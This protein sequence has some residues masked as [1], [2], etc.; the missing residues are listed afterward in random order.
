MISSISLAELRTQKM[1]MAQKQSALPKTLNA[2]GN[3]TSF[4]N[5]ACDALKAQV[6]FR[7]FKPISGI[8]LDKDRQNGTFR[9]GH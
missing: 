3:F 5:A 1:S 2:T 9:S 8:T 7:G 6:S 4:S